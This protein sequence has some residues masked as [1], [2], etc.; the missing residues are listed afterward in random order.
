[1]LLHL[2]RLSLNKCLLLL[3]LYL[4]GSLLAVV[5][6]LDRVQHTFLQSSLYLFFF[7]V[8]LLSSTIVVDTVIKSLILLAVRLNTTNLIIIS[9]SCGGIRLF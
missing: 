9:D 3:L 6:V 1:M 4:R 2:H 7:F 8:P 5:L